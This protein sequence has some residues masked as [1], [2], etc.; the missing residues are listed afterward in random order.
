MA[1]AIAALAVIQ[2]IFL[3]VLEAAGQSGEENLSRTQAAVEDRSITG[4]T[5]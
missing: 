1:S 4:R 5:W 2:S 3:A